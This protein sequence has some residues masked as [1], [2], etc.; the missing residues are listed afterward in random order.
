MPVR[1][2]T[3]H[4]HAII[5]KKVIN[6]DHDG[7]RHVACAWDT[8]EKDGFEMYKVVE[9]EGAPGY[10]KRDIAY[11]FCTERHKQYWLHSTVSCN[12]LPPGY[13][14]RILVSR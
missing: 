3:A 2:T 12:N 9:H 6:L 8:C 5:Q 11:V 13:R 14:G 10:E 7:D 1:G 4:R